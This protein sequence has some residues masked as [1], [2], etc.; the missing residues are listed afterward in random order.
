M[1]KNYQF[2]VQGMHCASCVVL[3]ETELKNITEVK[4][5]VAKLSN[6]IVTVEA[7]FDN[8]SDEEVRKILSDKLTQYGYALLNPKLEKAE[9]FIEKSEFKIAIPIALVIIIL[10]IFIQKLGLVNL[11][12]SQ[13][14]SYSLA[15]SIGLVASLSTCMAVV[16]G[17][18]LSLSANY[19]LK[20]RRAPQYLF[21]VGRLISFFILGG[22]LGLVG[23]SFQFNFLAS[24]ILGLVVALIMIILGINLLGVFQWT[25]RLELTMP[26]IFGENILKIKKINNY[27]IPFIIGALTFF[28]PCGFTQ[29]MQ[30]YTLTTASFFKGALTMLSFALGTFPVLALLS[31]SSALAIKLKNYS[32]IIFKTMGIVVILFA[33][34][35]IINNLA[36]L[37]IIPPI[38]NL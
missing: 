30:I 32:G 31:F 4:S 15:F 38:I 9:N 1:I 28:L 34:F 2:F 8:L 22:V 13:N 19:A 10:F 26:K 35:N 3:T 24:S 33:L 25:K 18:I 21:H 16:G 14:M 36:A 23:Q 6:N 37:G 27:F 20:A 29:S 17:L 5:A 7:D 12:N 11:I